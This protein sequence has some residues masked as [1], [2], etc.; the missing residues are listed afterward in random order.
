M[1]ALTGGLTIVMIVVLAVLAGGP[2]SELVLALLNYAL[3]RILPTTA[4]PGLELRNGVPDAL[5]T[6]VVVPT[7]ITS[8][9]GIDELV[10]TLE[11]HFL[12]NDDGSRVE[13]GRGIVILTTA[14][15]TEK[16]WI[17]PFLL[18]SSFRR[19]IEDKHQGFSRYATDAEVQAYRQA[20]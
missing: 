20:I 13:R 3:S 1:S 4:R 10:D 9:D 5:R 7:M 12:A 2:A 18:L 15:F 17:H 11:V 16:A 19:A 6:L 14:Q 8:A